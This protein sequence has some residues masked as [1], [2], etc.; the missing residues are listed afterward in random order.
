MFLSSFKIPNRKSIFT[1]LGANA[2]IPTIN[3]IDIYNGKK[4]LIVLVNDP[5][6]KINITLP[7]PRIEDYI[8]YSSPIYEE[9]IEEK[10]KFGR[11]PNKP[12]IRSNYK[13]KNKNMRINQPRKY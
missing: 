13:F 6:E 4:L 7:K 9:P 5:T 8:L 3:K 11:L 12:K 1:F 10:Y 2:Y